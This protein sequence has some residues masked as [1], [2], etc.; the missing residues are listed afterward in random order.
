MMGGEA[1][2]GLEAALSEP[3]S[4]LVPPGMTHELSVAGEE[5]AVAVEVRKQLFLVLREAVRKAVSHS[6]AGRVS[7]AIEVDEERIVGVVEDEGRGCEP[8]T[9]E[10]WGS[11]GLTYMAERA[12]LVS[13]DFSVYTAPGGG[14]RVEAS[15]PLW[16]AVRPAR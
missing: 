3:L 7:V 4:D 13:G 11:G 2:E 15:F 16:G 5:E 1:A 10:G 14:A 6:G 12:S 8:A 9:V